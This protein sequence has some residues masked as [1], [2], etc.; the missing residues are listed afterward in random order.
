MKRAIIAILLL[1]TAI[2]VQAQTPHTQ[3]V[4]RVREEL[5]RPEFTSGARI[6]VREQAD[7]AAAIRCADAAP[8]RATMTVYGVSLFRDNSQS[9]GESA[10]SVARQFREAH[11]GVAVTVSYESPY[12]RVEAGGFVDRTDAVALCGRVIGQFPKAVVIRSEVSVSE[13]VSAALRAA[14][15]AVDS[16]DSVDSAADSADSNVGSAAG[17]DAGSAA[18]SANSAANFSVDSVD[19]AANDA[20]S[21]ANPVA[22]DY[23]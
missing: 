18:G 20:V 4:A 16:V 8:H 9:A 21:A 1:W 17:F 15:L 12:F 14:D 5:S 23:R 2:G 22:G 6:E 10:R 7:A 11:P 13:A 19:P 3:G